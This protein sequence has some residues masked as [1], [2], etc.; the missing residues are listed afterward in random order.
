MIRIIFSFA[1]LYFAILLLSVG[2]GLYNTFMSLRLTQDGISQS[3]V[4]LLISAYYLGL[5]LG[6]RIGHKLISAFGHIRAY[7]AS[8]AIVSV[9]VLAQTLISTM[10]IWLLF[11]VIVGIAMVT[12]YMVLESWLNDQ[13]EGHNRGVIFSVYMMMSSLGIVLGQMSIGAFPELNMTVLNAV[14]MSMSLCLIPIALTRR[15][16][17]VLASQAPLN[18]RVYFKIVPVPM[19]V[20][21]LGGAITSSFYSLAAVYA[22]KAGLSN[23]QVSIF[24][25]VCVLA[26]L[27][28]Q[29]PMGY[30]SDRFNRLRILRV[31]AFGLVLFTLPL[32]LIHNP[33]YH[34]LLIVI[35][36]MGCLQFTFYPLSVALANEHVS[37]A[38]R[39]GLSG[40]LLLAF[41][42][43]A[44][45]GPSIAGMLM[46][47]G[48]SSMYMVYVASCALIMGLFVSKMRANYRPNIENAQYV[49]MAV[50]ITPAPVV[51]ELD[52]RVDISQDISRD[53]EMMEQ[54]KD[55]VLNTEVPVGGVV[56]E[57]GD[58]PSV[59]EKRSVAEETTYK[60]VE[61]K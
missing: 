1:S 26:G 29:Y 10:E 20:L 12:Q 58:T 50:D 45:I 9:M 36:C 13:S 39:V 25:S 17:P 40:A 32:V 22:N 59:E 4:G 15:A 34:L 46:D 11:R 48:G 33:S 3:W 6:V 55:L 42:V 43:G 24:L 44:T 35:A 31:S 51:H 57:E 5:V 19:V 54:V 16:H 27:L 28:A 14:A 49:P 60:A 2:T 7:V 41:S 38:M 18:L 56:V 21:F 8:A 37:P 23:D 61:D 47:G 30:L 52:P 53:E